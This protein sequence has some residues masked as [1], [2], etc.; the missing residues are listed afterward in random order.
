[1]STFTKEQ[2]LEGS[3]M[4]KMLRRQGRDVKLILTTA[5]QNVLA[6]QGRNFQVI[7]NGKVFW[8]TDDYC[9]GVGTLPKQFVP[10]STVCPCRVTP[11]ASLP[12]GVIITAEDYIKIF[13]EG[14]TQINSL[15]ELVE[16]LNTCHAEAE[17]T[18]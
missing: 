7:S 2:F 3:P 17:A 12:D 9:M 6:A 13:C 15:D 8:F 1:M 4:A 10:S 5:E 16:Y 14:E 11:R 18:R